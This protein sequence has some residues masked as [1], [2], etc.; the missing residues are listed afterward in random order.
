M[1]SNI[2]AITCRGLIIH[3][4]KLL[5]VKLRPAD[6]FYCLPGGKIERFE[7]I[8]ECMVREIEEEL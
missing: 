1:E 7:K 6:N 5:V 2:N 8:E 4:G 3:E